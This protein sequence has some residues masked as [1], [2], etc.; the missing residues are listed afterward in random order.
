MEKLVRDKIPGIIERKDGYV[1]QV[2]KA[3]GGEIARYL[4]KK[5]VEESCELFHEMKREEFS[6]ERI[7]EE[8]A[9]IREVLSVI[10]IKHSIKPHEVVDKQFEKREQRG[11]FHNMFLMIC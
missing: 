4:G 3:L 5:A 10:C 9:D 11:S 8:M 7:I 1:P 6:R 2:R